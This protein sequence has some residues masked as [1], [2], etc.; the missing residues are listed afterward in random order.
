MD[1]TVDSFL[2]EINQIAPPKCKKIII[3]VLFQSNINNILAVWEE[4]YDDKSG[5][6]YYWNTQTDDVTWDVPAGYKKTAAKSDAGKKKLYIPPPS[7]EKIML[8][9]IP[10][11]NKDNVKIY[12]ID[13]IKKP[14]PVMPP[15]RNSKSKKPSKKKS[16]PRRPSDSDDE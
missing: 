2:K 12:K 5:F 10:H 11:V 9:S 1:E 14:A 15:R 3:E 16:F 7:E 6:T 4:C 13:D 8:G